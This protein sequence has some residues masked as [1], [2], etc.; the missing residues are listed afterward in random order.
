MCLKQIFIFFSGKCK[1]KERWSLKNNN[2]KSN[3]Q[4]FG[5]SWRR[6]E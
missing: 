6:E 4:L 1:T 2:K 3:P 5:T